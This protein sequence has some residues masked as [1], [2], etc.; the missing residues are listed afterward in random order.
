MDQWKV[1]VGV[2]RVFEDGG[3][4]AMGRIL[5]RLPQGEAKAV[6]DDARGTDEKGG[7]HISPPADPRFAYIRRGVIGFL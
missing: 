6:E 3:E 2:S 7:R 1:F 4:Q 5:E